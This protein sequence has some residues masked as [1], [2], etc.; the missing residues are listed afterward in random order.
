M[1]GADAAGVDLVRR[2]PVKATRDSV[3]C[4]RSS[5]PSVQSATRRSGPRAAQ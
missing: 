4:G 2:Q 5:V 3:A 1:L